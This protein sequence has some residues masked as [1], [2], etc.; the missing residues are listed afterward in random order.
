MRP[1]RVL[2]AVT[3]LAALAACASQP[4][5]DFQSP[6]QLSGAIDHDIEASLPSADQNLRAVRPGGKLPI[7]N[8]V[9]S[10]RF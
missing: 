10:P 2:I 9:G 7:E 8:G 3:L 1:M 5:R 4:S 6:S